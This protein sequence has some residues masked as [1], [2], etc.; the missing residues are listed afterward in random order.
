MSWNKLVHLPPFLSEMKALTRLDL[1]HTHLEPEASVPISNLMRENK[2]LRSLRLL[3]LKLGSQ[4]GST[5][6]Q[7][8]I[9]N[10]LVNNTS[11]QYIS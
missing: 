10:F 6:I 1:S 2:S 7:T 3:D 5:I 8:M 11:L 9:Q 4:G